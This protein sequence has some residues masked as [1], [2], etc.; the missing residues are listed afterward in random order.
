MIYL[1]IVQITTAAILI[2]SVLLQGGGSGLSGAFGGGGE[3]FR[4]RRG[5]EKILVYVTVLTAI[6]FVLATIVNL[7]I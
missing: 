4:T 2:I 1:Q 7:L 6:I 3:A 5:V